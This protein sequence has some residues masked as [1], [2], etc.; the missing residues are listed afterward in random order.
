MSLGLGHK[1]QAHVGQ[2]QTPPQPLFGASS[3]GFDQPQQS[4][5]G[6]PASSAMLP[7]LANITVPPEIFKGVNPSDYSALEEAYRRGA[8]AAVAYSQAAAVAVQKQN[9]ST[10]GKIISTTGG[11]EVPPIGMPF[12]SVMPRREQLMS[13][14]MPSVGST[15]LNQPEKSSATK[16][17]SNLDEAQK[18]AVSGVS[19]PSPIPSVSSSSAQQWFNS[20]VSRSV[21][22]PNMTQY[23]MSK[24]N[25]ATLEEGKRQKRLARNRASARLRRLR[26]KNLVESYEHEVGVLESSLAKLKAHSWGSGNYDALIQALSMERG[27]QPLSE[28]DRRKVIVSI[29][30][31][32]REQIENLM[33][34]HLETMMLSWIG[35][36]STGEITV[37]DNSEESALAAE[38]SDVLKLTPE[39][40]GSLS[41][42]E[43][44]DE[45]QQAI[46]TIDVCLEALMNNSWL[47]NEGVE[48]CTE[49]F[50]SI[51][52]P[53]Q[54][55]KFMIWADHNSDAI[56]C[57]DYVNAPPAADPPTNTPIFHFGIDQSD[58]DPSQDQKQTE[59]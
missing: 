7:N 50:A 37:P 4:V 29:L 51:M 58:D 6:T 42:V 14:P 34:A 32:Q 23:N 45:E 24:E 30:K 31:Q 47:M 16:P 36:V 3:G 46:Q 54:I 35:K 13:I 56:D 22:L 9:Q 8:A 28:D 57:L 26:K 33:D 59:G 25:R 17:Q 2:W 20:Q 55:S 39:Q 27:Q 43:C 40:A 12:Q 41:S 48:E 19:K 10:S 21:S 38:L 49:H 5:S 11:P 44:G 18:T 52:N 15:P 53:S 1:R